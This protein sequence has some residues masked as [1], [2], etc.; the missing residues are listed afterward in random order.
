[1]AL[2]FYIISKLYYLA[3]QIAEL[4]I[5]Q[6][7]ARSSDILHNVLAYAK[8]PIFYLNLSEIKKIGNLCGTKGKNRIIHLN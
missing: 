8:L 7:G 1:V 6:D 3:A 2:R 5:V 4:R